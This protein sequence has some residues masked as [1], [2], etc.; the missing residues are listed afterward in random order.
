M[1]TAVFFHAHPD[2]E[3][4]ATGGTMAALADAGH[5]VVLVLATRGEL[6]EVAEGFLPEGETL[7]ERRVREV[8]AAASILG[9]HRVAYLGYRDSGMAGE[10]SNEDPEAF[11][12]ADV[13]E[14]ADRLAELL[15]DESAELLVAYDE[16]G[17][18]GHPDHLQVHRV[19]AEI[20][21]RA[22]GPRVL[23]STMDRDHLMAGLAA[24]A[25]DGAD[26][27]PDVE[28]IGMP[29]ERI[30]IAVDV[31]PWLAR[32]RAAMQAHASQITDE[33]FFL[34]MPEDVFT[35]SFGTEWFIRHGEP[36]RSGDLAA[37][38][39]D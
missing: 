23:E 34:T 12:Q 25:V 37:T 27:L 39:F 14:A 5:R 19:G 17:G 35:Y 2:D 9:V 20:A 18:Y 33:S 22:G 32:K 38:V 15:R 11:W 36:A 13:K 4:I 28:D 6:G 3:A 8:E 7:T 21:G 26:D 31:T 24:A 10:A 16:R 29:A 1:A 30:H